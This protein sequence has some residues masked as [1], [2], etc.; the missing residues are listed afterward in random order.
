MPKL[1]RVLRQTV[2]AFDSI[3]ILQMQKKARK[4]SSGPV[5]SSVL[6]WMRGPPLAHM[7]HFV[8]RASAGARYQNKKYVVGCVNFA[9]F[10]DIAYNIS[11]K[12]K[13]RA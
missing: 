12:H 9:D 1:N 5:F 6:K 8:A 11:A 13:L 4:K 7:M 10:S 2:I 3:L